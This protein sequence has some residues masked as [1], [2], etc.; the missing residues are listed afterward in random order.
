MNIFRNIIF[1]LYIN[2][3]GVESKLFMNLHSINIFL[4]KYNFTNLNKSNLSYI[5]HDIL[6]LDII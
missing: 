2:F 1:L 3:S 5:P 4:N 6:L